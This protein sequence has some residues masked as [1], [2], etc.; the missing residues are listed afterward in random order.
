MN[1]KIL[2]V[3]DA[4]PMLELLCRALS[5]AGYSI[6][7]AAS[8]EEALRKIRRSAPDL[9]I[10]DLVLPGMTGFNVFE[11]LRSDSATAS[12]PIIMITGAPGA[13]PRLVGQEMGADAFFNKPFQ[14]SELISRVGDLLNHRPLRQ[15]ELFSFNHNRQLC[16]VARSP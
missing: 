1:H 3:D 11:E 13:F 8:G 4:P 9:I 2:V 5:E 12:I 16:G 10:L 15:P 6:R 14:V 7:S